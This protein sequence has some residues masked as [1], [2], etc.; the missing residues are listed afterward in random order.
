MTS[1]SNGGKSVFYAGTSPKIETVFSTVSVQSAYKRSE[2]GSKVSLGQLRVSSK[3]EE[4]VQ[5]SFW[6]S[7]E[8]QGRLNKKWQ[9]DFIV[10]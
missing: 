10:I 8:V 1:R 3:L 5:K 6:L 2:F 7:S 4:R 9:E